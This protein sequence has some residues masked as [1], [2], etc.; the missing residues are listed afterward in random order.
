MGCDFKV[1]AIQ[2]NSILGNLQENHSRALELVKE[3]V[4]MGAKLIVLPELFNTGY[5]TEAMDDKLAQGIP[6]VTSDWMQELCKKYNI[7]LVASILERGV[8]QGLIYNTALSVNAGGVLGVYRKIHLW[9]LE[10]LRF[11]KGHEFPLVDLGF[12]K[13]GMQVCYEVGFPE[14]ARI[15][16]LKGADI[17]AYP[18]AF[19][20]A[21]L[22]AWDVATRARAL[23]NGVYVIAANRSGKE[24][25]DTIFAGHSRIINPR[26]EVI[27]EATQENEVLTAD[28]DLGFVCRQRRELP[29]LRDL[30]KKLVNNFLPTPD[31]NN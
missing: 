17:L 22:Y 11:A 1:A 7:V 16:A 19:G 2:M 3:A 21:R 5:R 25:G 23:E 26:G 15:L 13:L 4:E 9:D 6:G 30:N 12:V 8:V 24:K 14:G 27:V 10:N 29:Y 31:L 20:K 28:I 18:S